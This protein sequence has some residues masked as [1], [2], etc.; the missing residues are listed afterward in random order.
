[1]VRRFINLSLKM[2]PHSNWESTANFRS[3]LLF[4]RKNP[5]FRE[6]I[7]R[8]VS[9]NHCPPCI[10]KRREFQKIETFFL[11]L[12]SRRSYS[13]RLRA[14]CPIIFRLQN[15]QTFYHFAYL[16]RSAHR[17]P[18][19]DKSKNNLTVMSLFNLRWLAICIDFAFFDWK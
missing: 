1:M 15:R 8:I 12:H 2:N 5:L 14:D 6:A 3:T 13:F 9:Y 18:F 11:I 19:N 16:L 7:N 17:C 10:I 4:N